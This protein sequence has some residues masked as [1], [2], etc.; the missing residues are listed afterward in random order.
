MTESARRV[1]G[2]ERRLVR[3]AV[4]FTEVRCAGRARVRT[5]DVLYS[6][7]NS[8][9]AANPSADGSHTQIG[10][11]LASR[12]G[13]GEIVVNAVAGH[14]QDV[15]ATS[16]YTPL[17]EAADAISG[18]RPGAR[19]ETLEAYIKRLE[20]LEQI[21]SGFGGVE[22]AFAIQAGRELRVIVSSKDTS[23][24]TAAKICRD[25]VHAFE[26]QLT[27]P[28]EIKVTVLRE[29]RYTEVAR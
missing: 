7:S 29:T 15:E 24:E 6:G 27:Y 11:E 4:R 9:I 21:A 1:L 3:S 23:D 18:A 19:R 2:A 17:V 8:I 26:K 14:H 20:K 25:I 10:G 5:G 16:L 28:G 22:K 12:Y 13:E